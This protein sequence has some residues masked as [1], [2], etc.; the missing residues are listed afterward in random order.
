MHVRKWKWLAV[1]AVAMGLPAALAAW[2]LLPTATVEAADHNDPS[3]RVTAMGGPLDRKAD[4]A[5]VYLWNTGDKIVAVLGFGGPLVPAD[6]GGTN[7]VGNYDRDVLFELLIDTNEDEA[8]DHTIDIR[9]AQDATDAWGVRVAGIPG[10]TD[11]VIGAVQMNHTAPGGARVHAG[12]H[13]DPFFFDLQGFI[14]TTMSGTL[15]FDGD[16]DFFAG[17]NTTFV[18]IEMDAADLLTGGDTTLQVWAQSSRIG[19]GT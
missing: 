18:V 8:A 15:S 6:S 16:R 10:E 2:S 5:D 12:V 11:P 19:G 7:P 14:D 4:I 1:A 9:F 17:K 13:D 3:P